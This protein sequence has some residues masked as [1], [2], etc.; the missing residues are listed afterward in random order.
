MGADN[1]GGSGEWISKV[2]LLW[3]LTRAWDP[4]AEGVWLKIKN[5]LDEDE[6]V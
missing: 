4:R 3:V 5:K 6:V 2:S 1:V